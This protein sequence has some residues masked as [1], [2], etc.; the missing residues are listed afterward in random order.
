MIYDNSEIENG[1][2]RARNASVNIFRV[3][4]SA[5][6]VICA[7]AGT[8]FM[9]TVISATNSYLALIIFLLTFASL[10]ENLFLLIENKKY[11]YKNTQ[12]EKESDEYANIILNPISMK[13]VKVLGGTGFVIGKWLSVAQKLRKSENKKVIKAFLVSTIMKVSGG[14][15]QRIA[16]LRAEYQ[17]G[18]ILAFDEPTSA[19]DPLQEKKIYEK[20]RELSKGKTTIII[21]HRL[22]LAQYADFI[23]VL[24]EG[25]IIEKGTHEELLAYEG[26]YNKMYRSQSELYQ[27]T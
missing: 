14:Q 25:E 15:K 27:I 22:A 3:F 16:I 26:T 20:L 6:E 5:V 10:F 19:I 4:Q 12:L 8:L 17:N 24:K 11:L 18:E 7:F 2:I 13:E 23:V 9:G 21:S 1:T